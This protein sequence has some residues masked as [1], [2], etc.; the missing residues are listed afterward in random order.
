MTDVHN[1]ILE[2]EDF[3]TILSPDIEFS[4]TLNFEKPFL[5]RGKVS[6][7]ISAQGLLVV[8]E[9]AVV[10]ANINASRV[11][12]RGSVKG[13]VSAGEKV[14]VTITGRL[15]GNVSAPEIFMETGCVFNGRCTMTEKSPGI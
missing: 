2:D 7:E 8:D 9:E 5:I 4:G 6:G 14:E 3:D 13:D 10:N 12:I 11:I 1:D 15:V